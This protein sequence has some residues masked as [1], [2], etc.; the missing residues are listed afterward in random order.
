MSSYLHICRMEGILKSKGGGRWERDGRRVWR[1]GAGR[2]FCWRRAVDDE[3][4]GREERTQTQ[5]R[6]SV[7]GLCDCVWPLTSTH[8]WTDITSTHKDWLEDIFPLRLF[9]PFIKPKILS[10]K[11]SQGVSLSFSLLF[12]LLSILSFKSHYSSVKKQNKKKL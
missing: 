2:L 5:P 6:L 12:H 9:Y 3:E 7:V 4:C 11:P 1:W 10:L 8:F